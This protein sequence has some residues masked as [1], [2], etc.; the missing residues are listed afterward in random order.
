MLFNGK[1]TILPHAATFY[2][3]PLTITVRV[4]PKKNEFSLE[5]H[6]N[7]SVGSVKT[8]I[9]NKLQIPMSGLLS[10][11][12]DTASSSEDEVLLD[13][14]SGKDARLVSYVGD[15]HAQTWK[16][17]TS[18]SSCSSSSS[19]VGSYASAAAHSSLSPDKPGSDSISLSRQAYDLE[20]EKILPGVL[21]A[22]SDDIFIKLYMLAN[23]DDGLVLSGIRRLIHLIPTDRSVGEAL[24]GLGQVNHGSGADASP[25]MSPRVK[26]SLYAPAAGYQA[27][28][29][30]ER[31]LDASAPNMTP[32]RVLY[33][34][35]VLSGRIMPCW[36]AAAGPSADKFGESFVRSGG[37]RLILNVLDKEALPFDVDYDIRQSAYLIALQLAG[38]LLCG[39]TVLH[40]S[41]KEEGLAASAAVALAAVA[42]K[43]NPGT[44]PLIRPTPPKKTAL[45]L[46]AE[47][48]SP[49][50]LSA[51][52]I[53]Q[54]MP[55]TEFVELLLCL[56]SVV[57]A[58]AAGKLFLAS[59]GIQAAPKPERVYI[60]RRSR[61][62]STGKLFQI[63]TIIETLS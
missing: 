14:G 62:S 63:K 39:Q 20:E 28:D 40:N 35:E 48:R 47:T 49:L 24:D 43:P 10:V 12:V 18:N 13:T 11:S 22:C 54:T 9:A 57:W 15:T 19:G 53:V 44:S 7:E 59:M 5:S 38:Y 23:M 29:V 25:Q 31:I 26:K 6:T 1:R 8:K 34:L 37:L 60:G 2:G 41:G 61:D 27:N 45:D 30:L 17:K 33:N 32:F 55:E 52:K 56:V 16:V 3:R 21:M 50:A 36:S 58:A 51:S 4:D 46:T 42:P